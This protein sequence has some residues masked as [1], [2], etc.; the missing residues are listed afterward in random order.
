MLFR[1][2]PEHVR[3]LLQAKEKV[4]KDQGDQ[5]PNWVLDHL[6]IETELANRVAMGRGLQPPRFRWVPFDDALM[7]P[8]NNTVVANWF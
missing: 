7:L 6:G 4:S 3:E 2:K 5:F 1:S 8:L